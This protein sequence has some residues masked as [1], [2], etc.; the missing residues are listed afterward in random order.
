VIAEFRANP[1]RVGGM[2]EGSPLILLT[3]TSAKRGQPRTNPLRYLVDGD[4]RRLG[5]SRWLR[6]LPDRPDDCAP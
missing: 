1:G 2:F 5:S 3:T 6:T 4:R